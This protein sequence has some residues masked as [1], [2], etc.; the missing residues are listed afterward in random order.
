MIFVCICFFYVFNDPKKINPQSLSNTSTFG[1]PFFVGDGLVS[2]IIT[3]LLFDFVVAFMFRHF[4]LLLCYFLL[5][6]KFGVEWCGCC[7][8]T[9][10]YVELSRLTSFRY[11]QASP[12][13]SSFTV[14]PVVFDPLG[15]RLH[16]EGSSLLYFF[17]GLPKQRHSPQRLVAPQLTVYK[18]FFSMK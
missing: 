14:C 5:H 4:A 2:R 13:L 10:I 11:L 1:T 15:I 17:R 9:Y 7:S 3:R 16:L 8:G 12:G 18:M 6:L